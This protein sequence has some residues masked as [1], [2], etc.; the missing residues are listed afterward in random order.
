MPDGELLTVPV[1][2][3]DLLTVNACCPGALKIAVTFLA[4]VIETVQRVPLIELH[5]LQLPKVDGACGLAVKV[6]LVL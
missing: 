2:E 1:P 4:K 6:T 5:P 3:P